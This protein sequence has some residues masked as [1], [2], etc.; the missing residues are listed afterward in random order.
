MLNHPFVLR[1]TLH[2]WDR[3]ALQLR[4]MMVK[5]VSDPMA[6]SSDLLIVLPQNQRRESDYHQVRL[7]FCTFDVKF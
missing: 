4:L 7:L 3:L 6:F 5:L 2:D 1:T